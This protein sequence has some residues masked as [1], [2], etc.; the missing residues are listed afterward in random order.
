MTIYSGTVVQ[1]TTF[2]KILKKKLVSFPEKLAIKDLFIS[3]VVRGK[4][5]EVNY[6]FQVHNYDVTETSDC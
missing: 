1:N 4:C 3:P 5:C 6:F 2:G